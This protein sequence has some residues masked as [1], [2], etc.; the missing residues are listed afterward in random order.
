M[1]LERISK[2]EKAMPLIKEER[3]LL[4]IPDTDCGGHPFSANEKEDIKRY[5]LD[6][7]EMQRDKDF[8]D[9]LPAII[10]KA[11][12]EVKQASRPILLSMTEPTRYL[13]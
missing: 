5:I 6:G 13:P 2:Q 11:K 9:Y 8:F 7:A 4:A 12:R 1:A 3:A 10:K